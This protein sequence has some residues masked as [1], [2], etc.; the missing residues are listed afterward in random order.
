M[1]GLLRCLREDA[2]AC[3]AAG[4]TWQDSIDRFRPS[5]QAAWKGATAFDRAQFLRHARPWWDIHRHRIAGAIA[6]RIDA[7][8]A[9]G[10]LR[11][12]AGHIRD[13]VAQADGMAVR[14]RPRGGTALQR[15]EAARVINC[16]GPASDYGRIDDRL[17]GALRAQGLVRPDPLRLGLDVTPDCA[18]IGV[19]GPSKILF[20]IG[21]ATRGMFWEITSVP[22]I[23]EQADALANQIAALVD[24][25]PTRLAA[26]AR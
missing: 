12:I 1:L 7:A 25:M 3:I 15:I 14:Y 4:G 26:G 2:A 17:V 8:R 16:T 22:N 18:L 9:R 19:E 23:R 21:P 6:D 24:A 13:A 5:I 10:Q 20:A 11:I